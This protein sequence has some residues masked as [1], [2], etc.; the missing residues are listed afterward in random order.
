MADLGVIFYDIIVTSH[1]SLSSFRIAGF[2]FRE[3]SKR[4]K[5]RVTCVL[6][7]IYHRIWKIL[8]VYS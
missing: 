6:I 1:I 5:L 4:E 8:N 7:I 2:I 3:L